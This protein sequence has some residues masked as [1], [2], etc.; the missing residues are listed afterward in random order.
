MPT[1]YE[2][3]PCV[4]CGARQARTLASRPEVQHEMES[5]WE[6]HARRL[7]PGAPLARL[8][9]RVVFSQEPPLQVV[10]CLNCGLVYRN[11]RERSRELLDTY[12]EEAV[13]PEALAALHHAQL[14]FAR[15]QLRRLR[16]VVG[17]VANGLEVGSYVGAFLRAAEETGW[18]F[19]GLDVNPGTVAF[20]RSLGLRA[21]T[22]ALDGDAVG[23]LFDAI[24]IWNCFEQLPDPRR[25]AQVALRLLAPGGVLALRVPNGGYYATVRARL[26]GPLSPLARA[27]LAHNNLLGFPYRHGFPPRALADMLRDLGFRVVDV[28]GDALVPIADEWTRGWA[29]WE[30]RALKAGVRA[31]RRLGGAPWYEL[32]AR[33]PGP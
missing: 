7:R 30:E 5:L 32:Y 26:S 2:I 31:A 21:D 24:A 28:Q 15:D 25:A 20:V 19:R 4:A 3:T 23:G 22:G 11:P 10:Q 17:S 6:F 8:A 14:P 9:D 16:R 18:R 33:A 1:S 12:A 29:R 13:H 27:L